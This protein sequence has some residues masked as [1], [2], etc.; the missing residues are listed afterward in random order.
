MVKVVICTGGTLLLMVIENV[1]EAMKTNMTLP[2]FSIVWTVI[3]GLDVPGAVGVPLNRPEEER[4]MPAGKVP[5]L[6]V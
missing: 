3:V 1:L 6:K 5:L 4:V 2:V